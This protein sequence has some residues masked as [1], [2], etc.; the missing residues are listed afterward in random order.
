MD[1]ISWR[2]VLDIVLIGNCIGFRIVFIQK[3]SGFAFAL[4]VNEM[5]FSSFSTSRKQ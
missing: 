5:F 3:V 1:R 4:V 2:F